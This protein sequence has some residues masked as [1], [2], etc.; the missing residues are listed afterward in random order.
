MRWVFLAT[1]L[2]L[3]GVSG[4]GGGGGSSGARMVD[5][6]TLGGTESQALAV[7]SG[8]EAVGY[9]FSPDE[10]RH[11]FVRWSHNQL[12]AHGARRFSA[13]GYHL[14]VH[15]NRRPQTSAPSDQVLG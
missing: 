2:G 12:A 1:V 11:A 4:C 13:D 7:N 9:A 6:G 8:D 3:L 5:L 10:Q 14:P 15:V